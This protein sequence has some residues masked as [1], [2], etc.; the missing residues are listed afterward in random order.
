MIQQQ[1]NFFSEQ[2]Y[3]LKES[4]RSLDTYVDESFM[5]PNIPEVK[6]KPTNSKDKV[7]SYIRSLR[8]KYHIIIITA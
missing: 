2:N 3:I 6:E 1:F 7:M 8:G 4:D 5:K